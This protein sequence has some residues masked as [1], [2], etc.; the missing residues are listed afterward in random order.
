MN[1]YLIPLQPFPQTFQISL[2]NVNYTL[3]VVWNN[4]PEG[5]WQFDFTDADTN[6]PLIAGAPLVTGVNCLSG[7]DYLDVGGMFVVLTNGMPD[8]VPTFTNLGSDSNLYFVV[9]A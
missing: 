5:G 2:A 4:S 9:A 3:T 8:A 7:L 6:T 1:W